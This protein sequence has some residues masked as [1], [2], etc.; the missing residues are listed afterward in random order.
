V[1][2]LADPKHGFDVYDSYGQG[3]NPHRGWLT[4]GGT[5][6]SAPITAALYALAGGSGGSA[7]PAASLYVNSA[8][9]PASRY[10]V[11]SGGSGFCGG[12]ASTGCMKAALSQSAGR[13][14]NPN[15]LT[16]GLLD[17][18]Y[19][20]TG[21]VTAAPPLSRQCNAAAG[22]DGA[23]G[24]GTPRGIGLFRSTSPSAYI[25]HAA[26]ITHAVPASFTAAVTETVPGAHPTHYAWRWGDS[27]VGTTTS[28]TTSH[29]YARA[30]KYTV[31]LTVNDSLYQ[32]VI[33]RTSV[34]VG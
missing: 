20:T 34:T 27:T 7:W 19:P 1:S 12:D 22:Y 3:A 18:S 24:L 26:V 21:K 2:A 8:L 5:S 6:L 14:N 13:T 15:D 30:G 4:V 28:A 11:T 23:S 33:R 17:C 9:H 25:R 32:D 31:T 16:V 29:R 10:D